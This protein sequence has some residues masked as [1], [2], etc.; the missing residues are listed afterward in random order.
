M[1]ELKKVL[2]RRIRKSSRRLT[3][4]LGWQDEHPV[5][6]V[7]KIHGHRIPGPVA[8]MFLDDVL[9]YIVSDLAPDIE[10]AVRAADQAFN[11]GM[12]YGMGHSDYEPG[13]DVALAAFVEEL[14]RG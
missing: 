11:D 4:E 14:D 3:Q 12:D 10:R 5:V 8:S 2:A 6:P 7:L 9:D 1:S 13:V